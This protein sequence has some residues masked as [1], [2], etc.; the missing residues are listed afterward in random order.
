MEFNQNDYL[1]YIIQIRLINKKKNFF[2]IFN[3]DIELES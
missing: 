1:L 2:F 3:N